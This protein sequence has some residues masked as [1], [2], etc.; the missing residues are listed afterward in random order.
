[1]I[2]PGLWRHVRRAIYLASQMGELPAEP[3][4]FDVT[5]TA[6]VSGFRPD[7]WMVKAILENGMDAGGG[8]VELCVTDAARSLYGLDACIDAF[9]RWLNSTLRPEYRLDAA[10]AMSEHGAFAVVATP[11]AGPYVLPPPVAKVSDLAA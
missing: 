8:E 2:A 7:S 10:L 6:S 3:N 1:M 11:D 5:V 9:E 4:P